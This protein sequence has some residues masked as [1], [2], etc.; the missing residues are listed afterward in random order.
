MGVRPL[1]RTPK[2]IWHVYISNISE[3]GNVKTSLL[4][5]RVTLIITSNLLYLSQ[6]MTETQND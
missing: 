1:M 4:Q 6:E 3:V 2:L 5:T